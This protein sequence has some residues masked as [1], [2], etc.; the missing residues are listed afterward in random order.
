VILIAI[1]WSATTSSVFTAEFTSREKC[2]AA[3]EHYAAMVDRESS[4]WVASRGLVPS[5]AHA[6]WTC[7]EK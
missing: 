1:F 5:P 3:G 6:S 7:E 2:M 4:Q